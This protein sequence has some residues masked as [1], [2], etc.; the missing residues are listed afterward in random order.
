VLPWLSRI[1]RGAIWACK[2][3]AECKLG[4]LVLKYVL[5]WLLALKGM[6]SCITCNKRC[7][8][9][10]YMHLKECNLGFHGLKRNVTTA[11]TRMWKKMC[12]PL[13]HVFKVVLTWFVSVKKEC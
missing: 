8:T 10:A 1:T 3:L 6:L 7:D 9:Y 2:C 11:C 4:F 12:Y 13:L 5:P